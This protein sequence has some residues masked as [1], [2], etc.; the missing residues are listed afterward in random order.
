MRVN[1]SL[2]LQ[3]YL[4]DPGSPPFQKARG[5][6]FLSLNKPTA[7]FMDSDALLGAP[8]LPSLCCFIKN[9]FFYLSYITELLI[10]E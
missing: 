2:L 6:V 1:L 8:H 9:Y 3:N 7:L 5:S 10:N 4:I